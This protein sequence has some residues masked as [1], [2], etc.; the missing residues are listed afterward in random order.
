MLSLSERV[1]QPGDLETNG[2]IPWRQ[3]STRAQG[4]LLTGSMLSIRDSDKPGKF[5]IYQT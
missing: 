1:Q 4:V 3:R 5:G 2:E